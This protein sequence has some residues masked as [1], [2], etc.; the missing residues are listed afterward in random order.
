[1]LYLCY[2]ETTGIRYGLGA[3]WCY[4]HVPRAWVRGGLGPDARRCDG[5]W[6]T[7]P[8]R[9][10][11]RQVAALLLGGAS[12]WDGRMC[13]AFRRASKRR[14]CYRRYNPPSSAPPLNRPPTPFPPH[15]PFLIFP[16]PP[17]TPPHT[18]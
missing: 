6:A 12:L 16:P 14:A 10:L 5:D 8:L 18:P 15:P 3:R 17:P 4:R 1:M 9:R 7:E 11:R 2:G 13:C